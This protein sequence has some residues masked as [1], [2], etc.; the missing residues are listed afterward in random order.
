MKL[1]IIT[2]NFNNREGLKKTIESVVSQ[3]FRDY[4]YI[5]IDGGST[6]GSAEV[7]KQY[8]AQIT[9]WV[10][11]PDKGIYDAMNKGIRKSYGEYCQFL[12]SGDTLYSETV[13]EKVFSEDYTEDIVTGNFVEL[14]KNKTVLR[15]GRAYAREQKGR[16]LSLFDFF[17]GSISHQATFIRKKLFEQYGLYDD[18]YKIASDWVFFLKTI[19]LNNV[20]VKYLDLNIV[21]FNMDGISN[22]NLSLSYNERTDILQS[23]LPPVIFEDYQHFIKIES[24]FHSLHQYRFF[25]QMTRFINK[26]ASLYD[27]IETKIRLFCIARGMK[28]K[29]KERTF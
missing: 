24:D 18:T 29:H 21:Y 6:D 26:I 3:T 10:S 17:A 19:G 28:L 4:E 20:K 9:Y 7:I 11:E 5:I 8:A 1:S 22:T 2:I 25:F 27:L 14:Y 12:N 23:L 16:S 13:L 15:K